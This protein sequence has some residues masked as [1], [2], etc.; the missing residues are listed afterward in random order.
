MHQTLLVVHSPHESLSVLARTV[1]QR[2]CDCQ[3]G[4]ACERYKRII[5]KKEA[6]VLWLEPSATGYTKQDL[7]PLLY[8]LRTERSEHEPLIGIITQADALTAVTAA[9]MLKLLEE[10][11]LGVTLVLATSRPGVLLPTIVS[12][13]LRLASFQAGS[14]EREGQALH[15]L[16]P[17]LCQPLIVGEQLVRALDAL[18]L[19]DAVLPIEFELALSCAMKD[20]AIERQ[21]LYAY[22]GAQA[23]AAGGAKRMLKAAIIERLSKEDGPKG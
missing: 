23:V 10:P 13:C 18:E 3:V 20:Q 14:E 6:A 8:A 1:H 2:L 15:L 12:R 5:E 21:R 22:W 17:F 11:P 16:H 4:T 9:H 7:E 19:Q